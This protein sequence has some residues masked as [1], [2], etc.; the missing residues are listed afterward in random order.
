MRCRQ[1]ASLGSCTQDAPRCSAHTQNSKRRAEENLTSFSS[2]LI[3]VENH[4]INHHVVAGSDVVN[5]HGHTDLN[6]RPNHVLI[7]GLAASCDVADVLAETVSPR[8]AAFFEHDS[9]TRSVLRDRPV[10]FCC[11]RRCG[12]L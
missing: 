10:A 3:L 2:L 4:S 11:S 7:E 1:P 8:S 6:S 9:A 12:G 5:S